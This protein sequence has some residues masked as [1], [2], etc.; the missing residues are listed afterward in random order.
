MNNIPMPPRR[1]QEYITQQSALPDIQYGYASEILPHIQQAISG[2]FNGGQAQSQGIT[3]EEQAANDAIWS[4]LGQGKTASPNAMGPMVPRAPQFNG[5]VSPAFDNPSLAYQMPG[6]M[7]P[8]NFAQL[9]PL[10]QPQ[11]PQQQQVAGLLGNKN[12]ASMRS[13][14]DSQLYDKKPLAQQANPVGGSATSV[15]NP[16]LYA[17]LYGRRGG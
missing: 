15:T 8:Q 5:H 6:M 4:R 12:E 14:L 16:F 1:P 17:Q 2:M 10:Q 13:F 7:A 11:Q 3:P 9:T